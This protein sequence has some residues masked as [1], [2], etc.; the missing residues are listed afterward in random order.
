[1]IL[2]PRVLFLDEPTTGLDPRARSEVWDAVRS[3]VD[4]GATVLLTTQY[5][6]EADQL[7]DQIAVI[8][9]GRVVAGG[10]PAELK[11]RIGGDRIEVVVRAAADLPLAADLLHKIAGV[12][13]DTDLLRL[14]AP[15]RD[16]VTALTDAVRS[17][18]AAG[19]TVED[20]AL[21]RPTLDEVFLSLTVA[22]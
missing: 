21:R 1:M 11:S 15:V 5:L 7:A 2:A 16:R 3:L 9:A 12:P 6:D 20:I 17:L 22:S 4:D 18:D 10:S 13:P 19:I 14:T 8:D